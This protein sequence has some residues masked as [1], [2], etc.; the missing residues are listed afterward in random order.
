[1]LELSEKGLDDYLRE[2]EEDCDNSLDVYYNTLQMHNEQSVIFTEMMR[3]MLVE[4]VI[5]KLFGKWERF[6]ENIFIEYMMGNKSSQGKSVIRYVAPINKEHAYR[7]IRNVTLYPDWSDIEKILTNAENFFEKGGAFAVLKTMKA[8]IT[9]LKKV[10]NAIAHTSFRAKQDFEKLVQGKIGYLP[11][12][13]T[14]ANFLIEFR[15]GKRKMDPTYCE[16]YILYL[17]GTA[18]MLVQFN[19]VESSS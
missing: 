1:M 7:M 6:L 9:S 11:E 12:G 18:K 2:F 15:T 13:I 19:E 4:Y 10:R 17:K 5:L 3:N 14:P 8:E 16:H